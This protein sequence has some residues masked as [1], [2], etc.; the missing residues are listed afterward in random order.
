MKSLGAISLAAAVVVAFTSC[1]ERPAAKFQP[2]DRVIVKASQIEGKVCLRTKF[3]RE[4]QYWVTLPENYYVFFPVRQREQYTAMDAKYG[5]AP[6][7]WHDEGPFY[8]SEL[9]PVH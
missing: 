6:N 2:G 3:F 1:D 9:Q 8:E 4:D 7:P 5:F